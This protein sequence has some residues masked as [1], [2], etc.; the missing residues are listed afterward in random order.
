MR[1]S[2][3]AVCPKCHGRFYVE[4]AENKPVKSG[5]VDGVFGFIEKCQFCLEREEPKPVDLP[6]DGEK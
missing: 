3:W 2:Y 5:V 6:E 1:Y 4:G